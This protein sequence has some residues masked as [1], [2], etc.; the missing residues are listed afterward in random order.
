MA[1]CSRKQTRTPKLYQETPRSSSLNARSFLL[2]FLDRFVMM[3]MA[4]AGQRAYNTID[5]A[6]RGHGESRL[7]DAF[8][9]WCCS[10]AHWTRAEWPQSVRAACHD[11]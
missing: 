2:M 4:T 3:M 8:R 11:T 7:P 1:G 10:E 5:L 6:D 9:L